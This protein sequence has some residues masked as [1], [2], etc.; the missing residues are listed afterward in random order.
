MDS[1]LFTVQGEEKEDQ[2]TCNTQIKW[3]IYMVYA[4]RCTLKKKQEIMQ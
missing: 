4:Q 1:P 2:V 3:N